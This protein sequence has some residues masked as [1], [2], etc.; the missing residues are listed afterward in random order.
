LLKTH[1]AQSSIYCENDTKKLGYKL[2]ELTRPLPPLTTTYSHHL[3]P[4]PPQAT[5]HKG[6]SEGESS[7]EEETNH[8][9]KT[10]K[11]RVNDIFAILKLHRGEGR[12]H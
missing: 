5:T 1:N 7:K 10:I 12:S 8:T 3:Q 2:T 9:A 4:Q 11:Y 6:C